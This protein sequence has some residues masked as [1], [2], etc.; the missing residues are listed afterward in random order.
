METTAMPFHFPALS[1]SI[2]VHPWPKERLPE[3]RGVPQELDAI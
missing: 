3:H 2:R 1:V